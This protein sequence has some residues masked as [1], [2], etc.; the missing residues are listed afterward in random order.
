MF[1]EHKYEV[2]YEIVVKK[3]KIVQALSGIQ[4]EKDLQGIKQAGAYID[5]DLRINI[6][7]VDRLEDEVEN[8][9]E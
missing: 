9:T 1:K 7:S 8:E 5:E 6:L 2:S 4:A 3:K